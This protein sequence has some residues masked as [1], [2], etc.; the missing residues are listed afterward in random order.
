M[1]TTTPN[2]RRLTERMGDEACQAWELRYQSNLTIQ[3]AFGLP[4]CC[5]ECG[6]ENGEEDHHEWAC[7]N[8][9]AVSGSRDTWIP[10]IEDNA[11]LMQH[12]KSAVLMLGIMA[13]CSYQRAL[14]DWQQFHKWGTIPIRIA[15]FTSPPE[16]TFDVLERR[17]IFSRH[18]MATLPPEAHYRAILIV[19]E[20]MDRTARDVQVSQ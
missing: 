7:C 17:L 10:D 18:V 3:R 4:M 9:D 11:A 14:V 16:E 13:M 20:S 15:G 8:C 6:C 12:C 19:A 5:P 1:I 2:N